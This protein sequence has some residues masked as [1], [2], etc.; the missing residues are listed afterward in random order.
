MSVSVS[1]LAVS[2]AVRAASLDLC[3]DEYLLLLARPSEIASVSRLASDP[4]DN[5]L[6]RRARGLGLNRGRVED[7]IGSHANLLVTMGGGAKS[8]AAIA[9]RLGLTTLTL[10]FP[11]TIAE[12]DANVVRV[13]MALGDRRRAAT[14][15]AS[16]ARLRADPP[17]AVDSIYL[18]SGGQSV[19]ATSLSAQWMR[20]AGFA[21][22]SLPGGRAS[23]E[24]LLT[25]PPAR[26]L[27]SD[28]R[29]AQVSLGQRWLA[30]PAVRRLARVTTITDGRPW[31]CAGPAMVGEIALLRGQQ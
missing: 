11:T 14:W 15:Q 2:A 6:W 3:S 19:G 7:L 25:A 5:V 20:L 21:Q 26:L 10:H 16:L 1:L 12:V 23:L 8:S 31:T 9:R 13:A 29:R 17:K 24:T 22:R 4:A 30:H 27:R 28:Y 18:S